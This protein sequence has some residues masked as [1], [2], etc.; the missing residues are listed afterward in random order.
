MRHGAGDVDAVQLEVVQ[1]LQAGGV[2][3]DHHQIV[4]AAAGAGGAQDVIVIGALA[5][6]RIGVA[7]TDHYQW[8]TG[9]AGK[10]PPRGKPARGSILLSIKQPGS[11]Q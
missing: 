6:S 1:T 10:Q 5:H 11:P 7:G 4:W 9:S 2:I 8:P 3:D